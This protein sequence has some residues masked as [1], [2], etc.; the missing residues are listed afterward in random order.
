M[1][2]TPPSLSAR[3]FA[4]T[5]GLRCR[6]SACGVAATAFN[7]GSTGSCDGVGSI[8]KPCHDEKTQREARDARNQMETPASQTDS[9]AF[10]T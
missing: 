6:R 4:R 5:A 9:E 3:A 8:C 1:S 10:L 7:S 2:E